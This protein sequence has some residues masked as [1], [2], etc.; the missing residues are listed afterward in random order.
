[1]GKEILNKNKTIDER[2]STTSKRN[3][4]VLACQLSVRVS[5]GCFCE[6]SIYS[7]SDKNLTHAPVFGGKLKK[8]K[9]RKIRTKEQTLRPLGCDSV[10]VRRYCIYHSQGPPRSTGLQAP[11]ATVSR[12]WTKSCKSPTIIIPLTF[13]SLILLLLIGGLVDCCRSHS[14]RHQDRDDLLL[15]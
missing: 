11:G 5:A 1:M 13:G 9:I 14:C 15:F 7:T 10:Y 6:G 3:E 8:K 12:A 2:M 4:K